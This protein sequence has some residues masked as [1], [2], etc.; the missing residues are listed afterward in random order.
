MKPKIWMLKILLVI[1]ILAGGIFIRPN[2][3]PV[4]KT[5]ISY[6]TKKDRRYSWQKIGM[7]GDRFTLLLWI[8]GLIPSAILLVWW[9]IDKKRI[10]R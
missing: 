1:L 5:E 3:W 6:M 8:V 4:L 10:K 7:T 9:V 2:R